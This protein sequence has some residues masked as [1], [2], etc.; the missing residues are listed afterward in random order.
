[1]HTE[2]RLKEITIGKHGT[3]QL[4]IRLAAGVSHR[5]LIPVHLAVVR[6]VESAEQF[7]KRRFAAAIAAHNKN[8]LA[9]LQIEGE[10]PQGEGA[11]FLYLVVGVSD[12]SKGDQ[13]T[14]L[15]VINL[16]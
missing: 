6:Y 15:R 4:T 2:Q 11:I 10:R 13:R 3:K 14:G 7:G 12:I 9:R 8:H 1:M 5:L 16:G